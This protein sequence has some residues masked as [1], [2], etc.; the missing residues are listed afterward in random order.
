MRRVWLIPAVMLGL[1]G[2]AGPAWADVQYTLTDEPS[3]M[4]I[5]GGQDFGTVTLHQTSSTEVTVTVQLGTDAKGFADT[6]AGY[7]VAW[8]IQGDPSLKNVTIDSATPV[9]GDFTVEAFTSG[10]SYKGSPFT[11]GANGS[12]FDYA[13]DYTGKNGATNKLVFDVT[14]KSALL[15]SDFVGNPNYLF[16][17]DVIGT[18]GKT[19]NVAVPE[20]ATDALLIAGIA[21]LT[22]FQFRRRRKLAKA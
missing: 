7:A 12:G 3:G 16:A 10:E 2:A 19:F 9:P 21:G 4:K 14:G 20:P 13:I 15:I 6:K 11:S 17:V 5:V 8:D 1:A 18:N 22:L